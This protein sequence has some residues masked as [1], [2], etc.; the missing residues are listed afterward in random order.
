MIWFYL[1]RIAFAIVSGMIL[2]PG[3]VWGYDR[4]PWRAPR[5]TLE[6]QDKSVVEL[7]KDFGAIQNLPIAFEN[8]IEGRVSGTFSSVES[9]KF[10]NI[11]C[12]SQGLTWFYDGARMNIEKKDQILSRPIPVQYM[13]PS[14]LKSAFETVG[15]A[16]GPDVNTNEVR[17]GHRPGMILLVGGPRFIESAQALVQDLE[18]DEANQYAER[19][20]VRT[21]RLRYANA[22]DRNIASGGTTTVVPGVARSLIEI[23]TTR[24]GGGSNS[25]TAA[26]NTVTERPRSHA[27]LRGSGLAGVGANPLIP[28]LPE[29]PEPRVSRRKEV[30]DQYPDDGPRISVNTRLNAVIVRDAAARMHLYEEL[31]NMLDVETPTIE[32]TASIVDIDASSSRQFGLEILGGKTKGDNAFRF[33]YD[34]DRGRFDGN[35]T[36]GELPSFLDGSNLARGAGLNATALISAGSFEILSRLKAMEE[37]G[38]AQVVSSPSVLTMENVEAVIRTDEKV[39]VRVAGNMETDLFDVSTGVQFR[40]TPTIIPDKGGYSFK[41]SIEVTDGSFLDTTV[42]EIPSTRESAITTQAVVPEN[43]TLLLGGQ[44]IER[45]S[46]NGREVPVIS[47][48]PLIGKVF[49]SKERNHERRQ[50]FFFITP[51]LVHGKVESSPALGRSKRQNPLEIED[52]LVPTYTDTDL[53]EDLARDLAAESMRSKLPRREM[54]DSGKNATSDTGSELILPL[55]MQGPEDSNSNRTSERKETR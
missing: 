29:E 55:P 37:A 25:G 6:A 17:V 49:G 3:L 35:D 30:R 34:A 7:L 46:K 28:S 33:G 38:A 1:S 54:E 40:V 19:I 39:Y 5:V 2:L 12:E 4:V 14:K 51:R 44:F 10:L 9:E 24:E 15:F 18:D 23:M 52:K 21:F 22:A 47:K 48:I 53:S 50:R 42:D 31:I 13:T 16:S 27:G 32:I 43:R 45:K 20:E 36:Q 41:L 11:I 8:D 26:G